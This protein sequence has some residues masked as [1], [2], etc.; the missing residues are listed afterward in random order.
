[1][2]INGHLDEAT[3]FAMLYVCKTLRQLCESVRTGLFYFMFFSRGLFVFH[4]CLLISGLLLVFS[5]VR[6][7]V[8][9]LSGVFPFCRF[10]PEDKTVPFKSV[11]DQGPV[12]IRHGEGFRGR[13]K[14]CH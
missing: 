12:E 8:S 4:F 14:G 9:C 1:M 11:T 2:A 3:R 10:L 13:E 5:F 7:I 6:L